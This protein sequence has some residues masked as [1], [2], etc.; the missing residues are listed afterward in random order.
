METNNPAAADRCKRAEEAVANNDLDRAIAEYAAAIRLDPNVAD[1]YLSRGNCYVDMGEHDKAIADHTKAIGL[2]PKNAHAYFN[3]AL[4]YIAAGEPD[5]ASADCT[6]AIR[7]DPKNANMYAIRALSYFKTGEYDKAIADNTKAIGLDPKKA[8]YYARRAWCYSEKGEFDKAIADGTEAIRLDPSVSWFYSNRGRCYGEKGEHDKAIAD[9]TEAIRLDPQGA[10][11]YS[12]QFWDNFAKGEPDKASVALTEAIRLHPVVAHQIIDHC[13][14]AIRLDPN[15]AVAH[16]GRGICHS[17]TG[18]HHEAI[19]DFTKAIQLDDPAMAA[20][21]HNHRGVCYFRT[22][23]V[24]YASADFTE[25]I[26]L[27]PDVLPFPCPCCGSRLKAPIGKSGRKA[28]CPLCRGKVVYPS[29]PQVAVA[30]YNR[31]RCQAREGEHGTPQSEEARGVAQQSGQKPP[32]ILDEV[33]YATKQKMMKA[34][35][36]SHGMKFI[37]LADQKPRDILDEVDYATQQQIRNALAESH[38]KEFIDLAELIVPAAVIELVPESVARENI[39]LPLMIDNGVLHIVVSDP[40]DFSLVQKLQ[41]IFNMDI[42]PLR[43]RR[44]QIIEAINRHYGQTESESWDSSI[45]AEF[46]DKAIG[47]CPMAIADFTAAIQHDPTEADNYFWRARCYVGAGEHG[48][49]IA[50]YSAAIWLDPKE[51]DYY[52]KRGR[53][54]D[55]TGEHDK[56]IADFIAA[57]RLGG[58]ASLFLEKDQ[59]DKVMAHFTEAIR[60]DPKVTEN[61]SLRGR[62]YAQKSEYDKAIADFTKA[63]QL[64]PTEADYYARRGECYGRTDYRS[65]PDKAIADYSAA[66]RLDPKVADWYLSR[67]RFYREAGE[68]DKAIADYT[69]VIRLLESRNAPY[70]GFLKW[71]QLKDAYYYRSLATGGMS[72]QY[73]GSADD[74]QGSDEIKLVPSLDSEAAPNMQDNDDDEFEL[75]LDDEFELSLDELDNHGEGSADAMQSQRLMS[76]LFQQFNPNR[77][78]TEPYNAG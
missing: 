5:K 56:A 16:Y 65:G 42:Q 33:D 31:G 45:L 28:I 68:L 60:L 35:A 7:L 69:E 29:R 76:F 21:A 32:D 58:V 9:Y 24:A 53:C 55:Q 4:S 51:A 36:E 66:I 73:Q 62:C 19:A 22:G 57:I 38:G 74:M 59:Y 47:D 6:E 37:D 25:A 54:Y 23:L 41:F 50:D 75:S 10:G 34:L 27:E 44:E 61:Y 11:Y 49:A 52:N 48:K 15:A 8:A 78:S 30:Y 14:E 64:D 70:S 72:H 63:I 39:V 77:I 46:T 2:D 40:S 13:T 3:R 1:F 12:G 26:R 43:A 18:L 67:S 71:T 17:Q 20:R